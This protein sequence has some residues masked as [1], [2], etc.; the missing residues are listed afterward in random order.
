M[1]AD[2]RRCPAIG[3]HGHAGRRQLDAAV[4]SRSMPTA[5]DSVVLRGHATLYVSSRLVLAK[6]GHGTWPGLA[7]PGKIKKFTPEEKQ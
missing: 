2:Q 7:F 1:D 5:A 6:R 3:C 4:V